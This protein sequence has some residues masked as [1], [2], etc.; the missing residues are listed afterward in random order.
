M[1]RTAVLEFRVLGRAELRDGDRGQLDSILAQ[2]KRLAI[3]TYLCLAGRGG[4]VRRDELVA[5][6]W[7]DSD[8][9]RARAALNQSLYVLRRA[10]GREV[11]PG[12]GAEE[13]GVAGTELACD[14]ARFLD[15]LDEGDLSGALDIYAGDL[16][17]ALYLDSP[18]AER[19]L[20][21]TRGDLRD[22]ALRTARDLGAE[23]ATRDDVDLAC[24]R[25]RRA[26]E[27]VP[28]SESAA[29]GLVENLWRGG[30]RT[31]A[32]EAYERFA[33]DLSALYGVQPGAELQE[34]VEKVR[35]GPQV[36]NHERVLAVPGVV[37]VAVEGAT[38]KVSADS[39]PIAGGFAETP[40]RSDGS[41]GRPRRWLA[42]V[43]LS[44][45][46]ALAVTYVLT[47]RTA[48]DR[49]GL[50]LAVLPFDAA[51]AE[52]PDTLYAELLYSEV[53]DRM[54][55][56]GAHLISPVATDRYARL[57]DPVSSLKDEL[58]VDVV[59]LTS[60]DREGPSARARA[61][62]V[63]ARSLV[64][65]AA[66]TVGVGP[67]QLDRVVPRL[68]EWA[69]EELGLTLA[70]APYEP[71]QEARKLYLKAQMAWW[72]EQYEGILE[73]VEQATLLDPEYAD[74]FALH[75]LI[76]LQHTHLPAER[77]CD[78]YDALVPPAMEAAHRALELDSTL[79]IPHV[80][81]G[82]A[83]WEH[84]FDVEGG[85]REFEI[86]LELDPEDPDAN[87]YYGWF[88][89]VN[90]RPEEGL[91]YLDRASEAYQLQPRFHH[92]RSIAYGL[93]GPEQKDERYL[94][95]LAIRFGADS[96]AGSALRDHLL[97]QGKIEE[98]VRLLLEVGND[99]TAPP[100]DERFQ[101]ALARGHMDAVDRIIE[102][103][104]AQGDLRM[105]SLR[106]YWAGYHEQA[107][108]LLERWWEAQRTCRSRGQ[109]WTLAYFPQLF[110]E[111]R[112]QAMADEV[113]I[114]WR[115]SEVWA[116]MSD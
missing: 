102:R 85:R 68:A 115:D 96:W 110:R 63:D 48:N 31:A 65:L 52:L 77:P 28:E 5:L 46:A 25:Y 27:I 20:D 89:I 11:I 36:Q 111:P 72:R 108:D 106:S 76:L 10:L 73:L 54:V 53:I 13:V 64:S 58:D 67:G 3:L 37:T 51:G 86:A 7:P 15:R 90:G 88:L 84:E 107:L 23:A 24:E 43:A 114:P 9:E 62:L 109:M 45:A 26:L 70:E 104:L 41:R 29:R 1:G 49:A 83:L 91:R 98:A 81:L 79:V 57:E 82:H 42:I 18:E 71:D 19:W 40:T 22:R 4:F 8:P 14:A 113:G 87:I 78:L 101:F 116:E 75:S 100:L 59:W 74:A 21:I 60:W 34:L 47:D 112:V 17:P 97:R 66:T 44:A 33:S 80:T 35:L 61:E 32:L 6:F 93:L 16:L 2:P 94:R 69:A 103:D 50:R 105:A 30:H 95:M 99:T 55:G 38:P 39:S 56:S 92:L 12:R